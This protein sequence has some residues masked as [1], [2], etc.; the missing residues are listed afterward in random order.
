MTP[1]ER[2]AAIDELEDRIAKAIE[3]FKEADP[4]GGLYFQYRTGGLRAHSR[5]PA[6]E[7]TPAHDDWKRYATNMTVFDQLVARQERLMRAA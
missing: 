6:I 4:S 1:D 2:Q 5:M 3:W 7:G